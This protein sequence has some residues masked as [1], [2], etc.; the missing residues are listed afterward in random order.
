[1]LI[2]AG[3]TQIF[4]SANDYAHL[5]SNLNSDLNNISQWLKQ[6]KLQ[7]HSSKTKLIFAGSKHNL[8]KINDDIPVTLNGQPVPRVTSISC[9]GATLDKTLSWDEHIEAICKKVAGGIGTLRR[10]KTFVPV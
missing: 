7:H 9:L 8:H 6:N 1:M 5:V 10:I 4:S 3:D 2:Y